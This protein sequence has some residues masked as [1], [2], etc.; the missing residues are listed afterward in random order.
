MAMVA[1]GIVLK[2][3]TVGDLLVTNLK[4]IEKEEPLDKSIVGIISFLHV[5]QDNLCSCWIPEVY[6]DP[7]NFGTKHKL[8]HG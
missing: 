6:M 1:D 8:I 2:N 7:G 5:L 3:T 4:I